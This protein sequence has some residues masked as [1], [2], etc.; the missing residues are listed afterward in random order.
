MATIKRTTINYALILGLVALICTLITLGIYLL[1]QERIQHAMENQQRQ[2]LAEVLPQ[3]FAEN[4]LL[5]ACYHPK[6]SSHLQHI[7]RLYL[8][9][10]QENI[11][12]YLFETTAPDGYSGN[13]RILVAVTPAGKV[14]G[15]RVLEHHETPGLGDKIETRLSN[16]IYAF[17]NKIFKLEESDKWAVKK[18][19]GNFDQFTGATITPRAVV[20][21]VKKGLLQFF[22][23]PFTFNAEQF[24]RCQ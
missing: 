3:N 6:E 19:G 7:S 15:V 5:S 13:I 11:V 17:T 20:N 22:A 21:A 10:K 2:L 1:T 9:K 24:T 12:A 18:D 14:L 4:N 8:A 16:W 23:Q